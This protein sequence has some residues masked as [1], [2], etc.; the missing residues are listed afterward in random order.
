LPFSLRQNSRQRATHHQRVNATSRFQPKMHQE[1]AIVTSNNVGH[2]GA[3]HVTQNVVTARCPFVAAASYHNVTTSQKRRM[4]VQTMFNKRCRHRSL[5]AYVN[6]IKQPHG[7]TVVQTRG[8]FTFHIFHFFR[9][10]HFVFRYATRCIIDI[11]SG[12]PRHIFHYFH[13]SFLSFSSF[14]LHAASF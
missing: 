12:M 8:I 1:G 6:V 11:L 10:L 2:H 3:S 4:H 7:L 9:L 5:N 13:F 14:L